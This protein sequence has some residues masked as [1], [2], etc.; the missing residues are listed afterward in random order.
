M[1][2]VI[3]TLDTVIWVVADLDV[4]CGQSQSVAGR[5]TRAHDTHRLLKSDET[6]L[7]AWEN[8]PKGR[9]DSITHAGRMKRGKHCPV[10]ASHS[11]SGSTYVSF[12]SAS[13]DPSLPCH[14]PIPPHLWRQPLRHGS[15]IVTSLHTAAQRMPRGACRWPR[16][17]QR[18]SICRP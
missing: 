2:K 5:Q 13:P 16:P 4:H 6:P 9:E 10:S 1:R 18:R 17:Q 15:A 11:S 8:M 12:Q 3:E 14:I 7:P